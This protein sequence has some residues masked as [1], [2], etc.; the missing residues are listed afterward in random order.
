[1][2]VVR[3]RKFE[4]PGAQLLKDLAE[5]KDWEHLIVVGQFSENDKTWIDVFH[6]TD[7]GTL[8]VG[9]LMRAIVHIL[10]RNEE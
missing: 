7:N 2:S 9:M 8:M 4:K 10:D 1:M 5:H 3:L 6:N